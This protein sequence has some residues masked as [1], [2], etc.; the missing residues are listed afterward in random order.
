MARSAQNRPQSSPAQGALAGPPDD[1]LHIWSDDPGAPCD[2]CLACAKWYRD[3]L[4]ALNAFEEHSLCVPM[5]LAR[6]RV[7]VA[8]VATWKKWQEEQGEEE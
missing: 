4:L 1:Y 5:I 2:E 6:E 7:R 8:A 3:Q